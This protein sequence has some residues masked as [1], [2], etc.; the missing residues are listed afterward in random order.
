M[1]KT[2]RNVIIGTDPGIYLFYNMISLDELRNAKTFTLTLD[3]V[4]KILL[5]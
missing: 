4:L 1:K 2:F 3:L 5:S